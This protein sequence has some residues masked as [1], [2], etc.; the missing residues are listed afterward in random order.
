[1]TIP[2][3]PAPPPPNRNNIKI[4]SIVASDHSG[5]PS[6]KKRAPPRPP[7]PQL[8]AV[9][10]T[11]GQKSMNSFTN[12]FGASKNNINNPTSHTKFEQRI[13]PKIPG[14]PTNFTAKLK[15][16]VSLVTTSDAQLINF[17]ESPTSSPETIKRSN[18]RSDCVSI[19]SFCSSTSSP[20]NLGSGAASHAER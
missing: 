16:P 4:M 8:A 17:D 12:F 10:N 9:Q 7:P 6:N 5:F 3:R 13:A 14:P 19:G 15:H 11:V 2:T 1:M 20:I 18:T